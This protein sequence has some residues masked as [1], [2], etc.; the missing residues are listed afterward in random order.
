MDLK[1][2]GLSSRSLN[3]MKK[4]GISTS[5]DLLNTFPADYRDYRSV[6]DFSQ[7]PVNDGAYYAVCGNLYA[8]SVESAKTGKQ[9]IKLKLASVIK[10]ADNKPLCYFTARLWQGTYDASPYELL[11][12]HVVVITGK[13]TYSEVFGRSMESIEEICDI[14]DFCCCYKPVY[15]K[16]SGV[17]DQALDKARYRLLQMQGEVLEPDIIE[18]LAPQG[19]PSYKEALRMIHLPKGPEE[20]QKGRERIIFNDLLYFSM[21]L[22]NPADALESQ[23]VELPELGKAKELIASLPYRLTGG[24]LDA[25][26]QMAKKAMAGRRISCVIQGDVGCGKTTVA[27]IMMAMATASGHQAALMA[28]REKLALQHYET[29]RSMLEPL[30]ISVTLLSNSVKGKKAV[31]DSIKKG[32]AQVVIG[33]QSLL[34]IQYA[35]LAMVIIDEEQ[36]FGVNDKKDLMGRA[37]DGAHCIYMSATPIAR[38]ISNI[39]YAD[40]DV[41]RIKDKPKGRLPVATSISQSSLKPAR[42]I[43]DE[44]K[45]GHKAFVITPAISDNDDYGLKGI[46]TTIKQYR[47]IWKD[48]SVRTACM[49]GQMKEDEAAAIM[50][51]FRNGAY[52]VLFATTMIEVGIDISDATVIAI[53]QADRFGMSQLHQLRGRVGRSSIQSYCYLVSDDSCNKRLTFMCRSNDGFEIAEQ[54]MAMRGPGDILGTRQSGYNKYIDELLTYPAIFRLAGKVAAVCRQEKLGAYLASLYEKED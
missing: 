12:Y 39:I 10:G 19:L 13:P 7:C 37:V 4:R 8:V 49:H 38:T 20:V 52:D 3:V 31:T 2:T 14:S 25:V 41:I 9:Y 15:R 33:T 18:Y 6:Y 43:L 17:N 35:S 47:D 50:E 46:E 29:A 45:K 48:D 22:P 26:N 54:D 51:D 16:M 5:F 40:K 28:P 1:Y 32:Q 27:M 44:V 42:H 23:G 24:Q 34:G 53:E 36:V 11:K 21:N 30:G